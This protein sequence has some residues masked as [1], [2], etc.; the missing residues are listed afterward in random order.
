MQGDATSA[1]THSNQIQTVRFCSILFDNVA[2]CSTLFHS[3]GACSRLRTQQGRAAPSGSHTRA[4][5]GGQHRERNRT[6]S[7]RIEGR[8]RTS[9]V[10]LMLAPA[11]TNA[12]MQRTRAV[13]RAASISAVCPACADG[14]SSDR[15]QQAQA[16]QKAVDRLPHI[17]DQCGQNRPRQENRKRGRILGS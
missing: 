16:A 1:R 15:Q 6:E 3:A 7:N 12:G 13:S 4:P 14:G 17:I 11:R 9:K 10:A 2:Y 8:R 5:G